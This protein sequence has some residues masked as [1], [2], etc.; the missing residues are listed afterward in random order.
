MDARTTTLSKRT[1]YEDWQRELIR[2]KYHL[3]KNRK[4]RLR[5]FREAGISSEGRGCNLAYREGATCPHAQKVS[6]RLKP[7]LPLYEPRNDPAIH[8]RRDDPE[9]LL[10]HWQAK[11]DDNNDQLD[12][13]EGLHENRGCALPHVTTVGGCPSAH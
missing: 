1:Q 7:L 6:D 10:P 3:C 9:M 8:L 5:L 12:Q 2:R 4:D 13:R 11:D